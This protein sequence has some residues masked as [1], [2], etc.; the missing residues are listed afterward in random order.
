ME[1]IYVDDVS[2]HAMRTWLRTKDPSSSS[3]LFRETAAVILQS[4]DTSDDAD[5][6]HS[7]CLPL[8]HFRSLSAH[9]LLG[10]I[11]GDFDQEPAHEAPAVAAVP[12]AAARPRG[13]GRLAYIFLNSCLRGGCHAIITDNVNWFDF[14]LI[15]RIV[16]GSFLFT[17]SHSSYTYRIALGVLGLMYYLVESGIA[18][19]LIKK[20]FNSVEILFFLQNAIYQSL[21]FSIIG[22]IIE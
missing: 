14:G 10:P 17:N 18:S 4:V 5:G 12:A 13:I 9:S 2:L 6:A 3:E 15:V 20:F 16:F 22:Y 21:F 11:V 19:Y 1:T 8:T 7:F